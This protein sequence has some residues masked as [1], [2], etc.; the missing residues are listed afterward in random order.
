LVLLWDKGDFKGSTI[1]VRSHNRER[2]RLF[3]RAPADK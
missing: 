3:R 2:T 1:L